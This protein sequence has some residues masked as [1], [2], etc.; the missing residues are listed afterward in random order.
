M[1]VYILAKEPYEVLV[2][3]LFAFAIPPRT[4]YWRQRYFTFTITCAKSCIAKVSE[5]VQNHRHICSDHLL[6][7]G[8]WHLDR[9]QKYNSLVISLFPGVLSTCIL[10]NFIWFS[11]KS[12]LFKIGN[13]PLSIAPDS[14]VSASRGAILSSFAALLVLF[15]FLSTVLGPLTSPR[16]SFWRL[17]TQTAYRLFYFQLQTS[18]LNPTHIPPTPAGRDRRTPTELP[19]K[20][21]CHMERQLDLLAL[22][23]IFNILSTLDFGFKFAYVTKGKLIATKDIA[24]S[25]YPNRD[26]CC[27]QSIS[28]CGVTGT[29]WRG[30]FSKFTSCLLEKVRIPRLMLLADGKCHHG[31]AWP[32]LV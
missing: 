4:K 23:L 11:W 24:C 15:R 21:Q 1:D 25:C 3:S 32:Q 18:C 19:K 13:F 7:A 26:Q 28:V 17:T 27:N 14:S 20:L 30:K 2:W 16:F 10:L 9:G 31:I 22:F 5:H 8:S 12:V 6:I 29:S